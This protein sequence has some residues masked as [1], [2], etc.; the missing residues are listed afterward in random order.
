M[1]RQLVI[2]SGAI[3]MSCTV[4]WDAHVILSFSLKVCV[5]YF[6]IDTNFEPLLAPQ[7][8]VQEIEVLVVVP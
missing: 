3:V 8:L 1:P 7:F 6:V 5:Y 4:I 2:F